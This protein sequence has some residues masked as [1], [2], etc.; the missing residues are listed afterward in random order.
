MPVLN[1]VKVASERKC[2]A[3]SF[4]SYG[5]DAQEE[6]FIQQHFGIQLTSPKARNDSIFTLK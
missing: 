6:D 2:M 4:Y 3:V 5:L 1:T